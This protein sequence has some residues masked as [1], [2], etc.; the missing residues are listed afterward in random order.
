MGPF[1]LVELQV[2]SKMPMEIQGNARTEE[3]GDSRG[4]VMH[5]KGGMGGIFYPLNWL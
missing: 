3:G 4:I 5:P 1:I 2:K